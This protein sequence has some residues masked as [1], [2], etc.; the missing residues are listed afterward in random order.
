MAKYHVPVIEEFE[1]QQA[2]I[3]KDLTSPPADPSKGDRYIVGSSATGDWSGHDGDITYY[4]GSAWQFITKKEGM[5]VWVKDEGKYYH[6]NGTS[7][8]EASEGDMLKSTYDTDNDGIVDKA[9]QLDDGSGNTCTAAEAKEAYDKRA[10]YVS[11]YGA[12]EFN[13]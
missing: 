12:L 13:L 11:E 10:I 7:W 3:D 6:Y 4:D 8:V 1:W 5:K 2:V 9:E